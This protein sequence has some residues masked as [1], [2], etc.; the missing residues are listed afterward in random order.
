MEFS[1][2]YSYESGLSETEIRAK[3]I[4]KLKK[5]EYQL[6]YLAAYICIADILFQSIRFSS[7]IDRLQFFASAYNYGFDQNIQKI[8]NW[9]RIA[10]FPA[11][12][13]KQ[14]FPYALVASDFYNS[15]CKP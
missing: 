2:L 3:R 12:S 9:Q 4:E 13:L 10:A 6:M 7:K 15:L 11:R 1:D 5:N 14:T 8:N